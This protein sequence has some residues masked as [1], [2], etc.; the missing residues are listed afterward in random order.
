MNKLTGK[1]IHID[2][3]EALSLVELEVS[4]EI[5]SSVLLETPATAA[6]LRPGHE[7]ALLFKETEVAI[8]KNLAGQISLRNRIKSKIK[9]I[10]RGK[11]LTKIVLDFKGRDIVSIISS[12]SSD[13]LD[14]K[15]GDQVEW[16]VKANE[17][18]LSV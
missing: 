4:A 10:E 9:S 13:K 12:R 16:L 18:S 1:I 17:I 15:T 7:V 6:Y 14:L 11:I 3:D 2:S 5:F 8:A